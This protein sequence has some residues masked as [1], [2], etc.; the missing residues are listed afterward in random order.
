MLRWL[1][2]WARQSEGTQTLSYKKRLPELSEESARYFAEKSAYF[3]RTTSKLMNTVN[4]AKLNQKRR[5]LNSK[6]V[7]LG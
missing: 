3:E 1:A 5:K 6:Y 4:P 7:E 2:R